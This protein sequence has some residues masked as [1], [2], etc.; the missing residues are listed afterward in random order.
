MPV[1]FESA[2]RPPLLFSN[3]H[4]QTVFPSVFRRVVGVSYRRERIETPDNDF[5]DLDH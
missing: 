2:Y 4:V 3:P 1:I 5:L